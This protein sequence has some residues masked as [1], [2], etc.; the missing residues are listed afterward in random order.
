MYWVDSQFGENCIKAEETGHKCNIEL[1]TISWLP[2]EKWKLREFFPVFCG[3]KLSLGCHVGFASKGEYYRPE[4][5]H[6]VVDLYIFRSLNIM[7]RQNKF[8]FGKW[9]SLTLFWRFLWNLV[10]NHRD[11]KCVHIRAEIFK[12]ISLILWPPLILWSLQALQ[13]EMSRW[14]NARFN[15]V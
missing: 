12:K 10:V 7:V 14:K 15:N 8:H 5:C 2:R 1:I 11:K 13:N 4:N 3:I 9:F 6:K